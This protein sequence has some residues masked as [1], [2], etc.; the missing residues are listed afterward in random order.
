M[1]VSLTGGLGP[2]GRGNVGMAVAKS[3]PAQLQCSGSQPEYRS[4]DQL[5]YLVLPGN[6]DSRYSSR[7]FVLEA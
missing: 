5:V 4:E 6:G 2:P 7:V 3:P 1:A